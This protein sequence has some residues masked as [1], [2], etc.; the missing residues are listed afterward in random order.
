MSFTKTQLYNLTFSSLMLSRQVSDVT[1]DT[2]NEVKTLNNFYQIALQ[3]TLQDLDLDSTSQS[4]PLELIDELDN[5]PWKYVYKYPSNC[6]FFRR[7]ES[8]APTDNSDTFIPKRTGVYNG[9][10][11][12]YT[13]EYDAVADYIPS[14]ISLALLSPMAGLTVAYKLAM[15]S[16]PLLVGK[17]S[18]TLIDQLQ[19]LYALSKSQA[20]E[21]DGFENFNYDS[22][23]VRSEFVSARMT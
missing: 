13:N 22:P 18:K 10:K 19:M 1:S 17:G 6:A 14:D 11:V 12:I 20:Q 9:Q 8:C 16:A 21:A 4:A 2:S 3:S 23:I 7:I 5:G 15:L